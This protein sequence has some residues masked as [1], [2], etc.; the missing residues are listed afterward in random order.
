MILVL[1]TIFTIY[2]CEYYC[3]QIFN[4]NILFQQEDDHKCTATITL[5][6][7]TRCTVGEKSLQSIIDNFE[8]LKV[9]WEWLLDNYLDTE[10]NARIHGVDVNMCTFDYVFKAY[11]GELQPV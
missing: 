5:L 4:Q 6:C 7:P 1:V 2:F 3:F 10:I 9:L 8:S 11:L